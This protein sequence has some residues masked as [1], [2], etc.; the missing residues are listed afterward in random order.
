MEV[1]SKRLRAPL[2]RMANFLNSMKKFF[3]MVWADSKIFFQKS[4]Q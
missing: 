1:K 2:P 3:S 4:M